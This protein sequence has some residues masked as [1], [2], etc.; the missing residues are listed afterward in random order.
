MSILSSGLETDTYKR[1]HWQYI[2]NK[3]MEL[4]ADKYLK[5]QNM[6]DV[7]QPEEMID[8]AK[9]IYSTSLGG[10]EIKL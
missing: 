4:I 9:L 2:V 1:M 7:I 10:W 8:G 6:L 5:L 3:N